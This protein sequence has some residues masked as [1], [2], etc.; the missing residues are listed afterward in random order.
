MG[1]GEAAPKG[2]SFVPWLPLLLPFLPTLPVTSRT[3]DRTRLSH[4]HL[5]QRGHAMGVRRREYADQ[6]IAIIFLIQ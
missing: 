6:N 5:S 1:E 3:M 2:R 4:V